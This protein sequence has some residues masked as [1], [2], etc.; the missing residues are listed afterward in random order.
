MTVA[1]SPYEAAM[2]DELDRLHPRLRPYFSAVPAGS[3]GRG[4]G[5]F[6]VVGTPRRWLWPALWVLGRQGVLFA[7]DR[8]DV[9]FRVENRPS[10]T[11][12][13]AVAVTAVRTFAFA[14]GSRHMVDEIMA[15]GDGLEDHLGH[16]HR[17]S[18][19]LRATVVD[20]A[21]TM[22][23]TSTA[24]RLGPVR[25]RVPRAVAPRVTLHESFDE[26]VGRQRVSVVLDSPTL[27]RL[28]EYTGHFDYEVV[29]DDPAQPVGSADEQH[30]T[31]PRRR[32]PRP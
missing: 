24:L 6:T 30:P 18:A 22:V 28:Y 27:G 29:A 4:R 31:Q 11:A 19:R 17:W 23:S 13:G 7:V 9:P 3:V 1:R 14:D 15:R 5:T 32:G 25:L 2:G 21:L 26:S 8:R 10:T 20:G 12:S 16:R